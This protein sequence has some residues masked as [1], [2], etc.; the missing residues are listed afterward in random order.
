MPKSTHPPSSTTPLQQ[1]RIGDR[2]AG[3]QSST[4]LLLAAQGTIPGFD[5]AI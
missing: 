2:S 5:A 4:F 1:S 3:V